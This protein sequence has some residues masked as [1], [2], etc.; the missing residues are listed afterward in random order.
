MYEK[1][2]KNS[3]KTSIMLVNYLF[4]CLN[5]NKIMNLDIS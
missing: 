4:L 1:Y 3:I 2:R 5:L